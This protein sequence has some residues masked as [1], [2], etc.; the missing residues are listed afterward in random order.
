MPYDTNFLSLVARR[1]AE[2]APDAPSGV[3]ASIL[4]VA[5]GSFGFR[6]PSDATIPTGFDPNAAAL[7][8]SI[9]ESAYLVATAD[10]VFDD[11]EREAFRTVV[12]EA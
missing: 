6:S 8:E 1:V 10:N 5:A 11:A 12:L 9:V 4:T 3:V 2:P 7:F